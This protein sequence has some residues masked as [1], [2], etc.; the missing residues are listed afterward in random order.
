MAITPAL[1]SYTSSLQQ[2][3]LDLAHNGVT[4]RT[5]HST[6]IASF[7]IAFIEMSQLSKTWT[8]VMHGGWPHLSMK[9]LTCL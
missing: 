3:I 2:E 9:R 7:H 5:V 1:F 6:E 8:N 4:T